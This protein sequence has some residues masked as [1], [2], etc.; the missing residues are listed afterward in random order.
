MTTNQVR[1]FSPSSARAPLAAALAICGLLPVLA[2]LPAGCSVQGRSA[3]EIPARHPVASV[4]LDDAVT[5]VTQGLYEEAA[6]KLGPL[7]TRFESRG[8]ADL[9]AKALF[10][11][12]YCFEKQGD[13]DQASAL[14]TRV[15][16]G[17]PN[18]PAAR[19]AAAR[20][21]ILRGAP[22]TT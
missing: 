3:M 2:L 10:W 9:A 21:E 4:E 1:R 8:D 5:L 17:Y 7:A 15:V 14:Y 19:Q 22:A 11:H 6:T 16:R 18:S 20:L 12:G 13:A